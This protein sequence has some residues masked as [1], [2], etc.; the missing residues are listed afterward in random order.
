MKKYVLPRAA[1]GFMAGVTLGTLIILCISLGVGE[2]KVVLVTP[3]FLGLCGG[4]EILAFGAESLL[5]GL[6]GLAFAEASVSFTIEAWSFMRQYLVFCL[7]SAAVWIPVCLLCWFPRNFRGLLSLV[8]SFSGTY[9]INW[10][11]QLAVSRRNVRAM[12]EV[13]KK[14]NRK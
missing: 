14:E 6:I 10:F 13:L 12:N 2:G 7:S 8:I 11:V 5:M 1:V 4:N 9:L 3:D